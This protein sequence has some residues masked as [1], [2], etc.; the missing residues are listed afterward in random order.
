[1]VHKCVVYKASS[2]KNKDTISLVSNKSI[3]ITICQYYKLLIDKITTK[4]LEIRLHHE[5]RK[6]ND[7][8]RKNKK[9]KNIAH[10]QNQSI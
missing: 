8:N 4:Y 6:I 9:L 10:F 3:I 1:M 5:A 7:Q 2:N